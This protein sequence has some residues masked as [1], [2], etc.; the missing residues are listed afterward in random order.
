MKKKCFVTVVNEDYRELME[1]L[2]K[3]HKLFC[4]FDLIVYTINFSV[5]DIKSEK[6]FFKQYLDKNLWEY[7]NLN[8]TDVIKNEYEKHKY[9]TLLKPLILKESLIESCGCVE[10]VYLVI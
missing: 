6:I 1:Q 8:K 5:S 7:K 3:S 9:T 2:I 10:H 4:N